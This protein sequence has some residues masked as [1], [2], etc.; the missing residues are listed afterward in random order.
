VRCAP[1]SW[2]PPSG[3]AERP[4]PTYE[5]RCEACGSRFERFLLRLLR[6]EDRVCP[7]CGSTKVKVGVGGGFVSAAPKP[8]C[9]PRGG[10]T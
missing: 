4:V 8:G 2:A 7:T 6:D 5:L 1:T 10:F 9:E 3:S